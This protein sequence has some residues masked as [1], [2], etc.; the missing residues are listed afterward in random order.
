MNFLFAFLLASFS[1]LYTSLWGAFKDTPFEG[2]KPGT[3]PRSV[4]FGAVFFLVLFVIPIYNE[5]LLGLRYFHIFFLMMGL[6]RIAAEIYK[7][8][9]RTENQDKYFVPSRITFLGKFVAI[10]RRLNYSAS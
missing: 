9:F 4:Y 10:T 2:F 8:F 1:G 5:R 7:G 6:E 3:F